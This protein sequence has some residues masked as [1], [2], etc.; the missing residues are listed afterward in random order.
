MSS[1]L[2]GLVGLLMAV[3]LV[4][5]GSGKQAARDPGGSGGPSTSTPSD[6][7]TDSALNAVPPA[8]RAQL[9]SGT[10]AYR[11]GRIKEARAY[12]Q[13]VTK[14]SPHLAAGWFGVYMVDTQLGDSVAAD[15]AFER[16]RSLDPSL[17]GATAHTRTSPHGAMPM[18]PHGSMPASP[19]GGS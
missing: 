12:Y 15:T 16:A 6:S 2:S 7:A 13:Q 10:S 19:H 11:E 1:R 18:S 8:V 17:T 9:D 14:M 3:S 5:C 4:A